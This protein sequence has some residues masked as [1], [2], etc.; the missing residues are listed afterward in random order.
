MSRFAKGLAFTICVLAVAAIAVGCSSPASSQEEQGTSPT[1]PQPTPGS[2]L[3]GP[4]NGLVQSSTGGG[5]TIEVAW[6]GE[7]N[8]LLVFEVVMDTHSV[9]L[10][11]YNLKDLTVLRF[12]IGPEAR[13]A[14]WESPSGGHHVEGTLTFSDSQP[15]IAADASYL[16]LVIRNLAGVAE[17]VF[18]W[19]L[20]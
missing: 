17:R 18:R 19:E 8:N 3:K 1:G 16:E 13:A 6:E 12:G 2:T 4:S 15:L 14:A 5:V 9:N 7:R 20:R 10:D 11:Q